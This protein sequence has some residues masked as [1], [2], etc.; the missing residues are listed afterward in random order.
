MIARTAT[1]VDVTVA[2][3]QLRVGVWDAP[4]GAPTALLV[5]GV[6]SSHL[7]WEF[8]AR[9]LPDVRAIAPD[10]RGRGRSNS[11]QGPA[12]MAAHAADLAAT[13][14]RLGIERTLVVGHSMGGFVSVVFA[15][16]YPERVSR[17]L[18]VDGGLPLEVPPGVDPDTLVELILGPAAARLEMRFQSVDEYL[19]FWRDHPAFRGDWTP[20]LERYLAYDLDDDGDGGLRP[21]PCY[22]AVRE[23]NIDMT[24]GTALRDALAALRHQTRLIT[25]PCGLQNE[26]PGLYRPEY[27]AR[28][29]GQYP[30]VVHERVPG[31][32]HYTIVMSEA[33]SGVV[34]EAVRDEL[35]V[36]R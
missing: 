23:D 10:L 20:E 3:G 7:A 25:V 9:R 17:L 36:V 11:L 16:L 2:G 18:L 4:D 30:A 22:R 5:H 12:G 19:D 34:A 1:P 26:E 35:A 24:T 29:L 13:L 8:L 21:A 6:T 32:N 27:L 15:H 31:F 28:V 14:D 33:G